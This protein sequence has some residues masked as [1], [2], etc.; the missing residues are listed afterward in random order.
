MFRGKPTVQILLAAT[1]LV[2]AAALTV[3]LLPAGKAGADTAGSAGDK[4][5][6]A[7]VASAPGQVEPKG[8]LIRVTATAT[9]RVTQV[10]VRIKDRV[11]AG[12]VMIQF[13]EEDL[14]AKLAAAESEVEARKRD[15][16]AEKVTGAAIDRRTADDNLYTAER[17]LVQARINFDH[18]LARLATGAGSANVVDKARSIVATAEDEVERL[19]IEARRVHS[20]PGIPLHTRLEASLAAARADVA[21][22][23]AAISRT[24]VRAPVDGTVLQLGIKTGETAA[25]S[26]E[27]PLAVLGDTTSLRVR[28]E[29]DERSAGK[30]RAGQAAVVSSDA[31]PGQRFDARV[32]SISPSFSAPRLT[33]SGQRGRSDIDVLQVVL[34]LDGNPPFLPGARVDVFFK[35]DATVQ[36]KPD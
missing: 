13:D 4:A 1:V 3:A 6:P 25:P 15:R 26:P 5:Q 35:P 31:F 30:I 33:S 28:A 27:N 7:W 12:D 32:E 9:G 21:A 24:R 34:N 10:L 19:R 18:A 16:D 17:A 20:T 29:L 36:A 8:G 11:H 23:D 2:S 14:P 22:L